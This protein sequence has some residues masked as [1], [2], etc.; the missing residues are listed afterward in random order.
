MKLPASWPDLVMPPS[1]LLRPLALAGAGL[2]AGQWLISDVMHVPGGGLGLL[3]AGGV[4]IWLGRK[5]RQPRFAA[6]VSLD[7][8]M[9]RCQEVLDQ[10]ARFEQQPSADLVRRAE[11]K[12]VLDRCGPVRMAMVALG[13][14]QGPNE[15]DLSSSLAGPT[16]V[17]LSLCHPLTTDDGSRSWP[18]GLLDQDLILFS[19]QAPLLASDLLWLQQVPDDQ[20]AWLLVSTDAKD[21]S[22]DA[23][24]A[25][26]DDLPERW[27]ERI[28]V[29]ESSMQL[30]TA[31]APLRRSLKQAAVE[32]RP[33]LLADLHRRW[34]RDLESLRRERFLQIQQRTQWLVAG[35]V[36]AS[37][38][39][40]LDLLAVA[41]ANGLMIK[42]MGEIW[43]TSLQPD[44]L[45][46]A[47]AKLARVAL[48]Q[49]V[50]EWTGQTLLGLAKLDGGSWLIAGS[51]QALSAA[52]LTRVV[53][54][55]MA[56]WL[57][58]NAGVDELDLVALKQQ[59][60]LLVAR[61]AEEERVNWNGFVQQSR[62]WLLHATS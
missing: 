7:G 11:L 18:G 17:T 37:P 58:I 10:F 4:V 52:Y 56:D 50:V 51:M 13:G 31:L 33:R 59:A 44:V 35:S 22:T 42:E 3:A 19:L 28:L 29:Q 6:P 54:R 32:T 39:A 2:L 23:V 62:E 36:M 25:V 34:Q 49:G 53:G 9:A 47:A 60:P 5:P 43:G 55:S 40:S 26:R 1:S 16:P 57:A 15:A 14:S 46:E 27:R 21:A 20:P 38:I 8:W 41:V 12:R 24:A 30:R 61:A 45:R 48:A